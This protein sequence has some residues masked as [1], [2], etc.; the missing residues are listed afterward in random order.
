MVYLDDGCIEKLKYV[1]STLNKMKFF[2]LM[3]VILT[4]W[5]ILSVLYCNKIFNTDMFWI[6][7]ELLSGYVDM[8]KLVFKTLMI[9][10]IDI[11][12]LLMLGTL[13]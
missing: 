6:T 7:T 2:L 13:Y 9:N 1:A 4:E 5:K 3:K 10:Y 8:G 11:A 12:I